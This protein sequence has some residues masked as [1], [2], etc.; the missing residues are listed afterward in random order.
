MFIRLGWLIARR[1]L[2]RNLLAVV[3]VA[4]ASMMLIAVTVLGAGL[5]GSAYRGHRQVLGGDLVVVPGTVALD[6]A[7]PPPAGEWRWDRWSRDFPGI[8][9]T[10]HPQLVEWG[11]LVLEHD[12]IYS[13]PEAVSLIE[14]HPEVA[15][16]YPYYSYPV[17]VRNDSSRGHVAWLRPRVPEW[18]S[19]LGVEQAI[20]RGR[21]FSVTDDGQHVALVDGYR[22]P[23][24]P[25]PLKGYWAVWTSLGPLLQD[26]PPA[27][28]GETLDIWIPRIIEGP[29]GS[30]VDYTQ[31]RFQS[32]EVVGHLDLQTSQINWGG[33]MLT[34][35]GLAP[36][37]REPGG[38][39]PYSEEVLRWTTAE[40]WVP[41]ETFFS[42]V[43]PGENLLE[44]TELVVGLRSLVRLQQVAG[45]LARQLEGFQVITVADLVS[46]TDYLPEP[47]FLTPPEDLAMLRAARVERETGG[48]SLPRWFQGTVLIMSYLL[49]GLLFTGNIYVLLSARRNEIGVLGALGATPGQVLTS[50]LTESLAIG[51]SGALLGFA[52]MSPLMG[53]HFLSNR[54][55]L[56]EW[57]IHVGRTL[58]YLLLASGLLA[59]VFGGI[60]ALRMLKRPVKEV[61]GGG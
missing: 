59:V 26:Y 5:P 23:E 22:A 39:G 55:T 57:W 4:T 58:V 38:G 48:F 53:W 44:P 45:E 51:L 41:W 3:S 1:N 47:H 21:S 6:G 19:I 42:L 20:L 15:F 56:A 28:L 12:S 25:G 18:D 8:L 14:S 17:V 29:G 37:T 9:G 50:L 11:G 31:G 16:V 46:G 61:L 10:L 35:G 52:L 30:S 2:N 40:I 32:L 34:P 13:I 43:S 33:Q 36:V 7:E 24:S 27:A 60:P 49:A 54:L